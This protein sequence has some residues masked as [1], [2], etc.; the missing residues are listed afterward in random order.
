[1]ERRSFL[2]ELLLLSRSYAFIMKNEENMHVITVTSSL[3]YLFI[4]ETILFYDERRN[5]WSQSGT[6]GST[7][8]VSSDDN[9]ETRMDEGLNGLQF[10]PQNWK[11][12]TLMQQI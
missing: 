3:Q 1:M 6:D 10:D 7:Y 9:S 5:L 2:V 12:T 8:S 4:T 11:K